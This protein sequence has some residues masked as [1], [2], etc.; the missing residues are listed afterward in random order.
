MSAADRFAPRAL[1]RQ[2][3][4]LIEVTPTEHSLLIEALERCARQPADDPETIDFAQYLFDRI[5]Q[6]REAGR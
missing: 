3:M 4:I 2:M 5:A 6:L 1:L